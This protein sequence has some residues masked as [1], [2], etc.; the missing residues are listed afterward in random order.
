MHSLIAVQLA[1]SLHAS[2]SALHFPTSDAVEHDSHA[3]QSALIVS[4]EPA[5]PDDPVDPDEPPPLL[6]ELTELLDELTA[7]PEELTA[8]LPPAPPP[9]FVVVSSMQPEAMSA[10]AEQQSVVAKRCKFM[11]PPPVE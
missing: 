11:F 4:H 3:V 5:P 10:V 9:P 7:P 6:D 2:D 1:E 8:P